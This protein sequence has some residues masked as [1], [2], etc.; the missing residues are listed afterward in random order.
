MD[1]VVDPVEGRNLLARGRPDSIAVAGVAP[2]GSMW[3]PDPAVYMEKIVVGREVAAALVP[4]CMDAP[5]AW[6]V[7]LVARVKAKS[8]RDV[9][10]FVLDRPRV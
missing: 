3:S 9:V 8:V 5:A 1:V 7:A 4:E 2:R 6:T 10:V